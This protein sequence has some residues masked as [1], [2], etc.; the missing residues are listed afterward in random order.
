MLILLDHLATIINEA[1][2]TT[3]TGIQFME[4]LETPAPRPMMSTMTPLVGAGASPAAPAG[5]TD[6]SKPKGAIRTFQY[7]PGNCQHKYTR[8]MK[9][10]GEFC[11]NGPVTGTNFC[12]IHHKIKK[13]IASGGTTAV[14][15]PQPGSLIGA[16]PSKEAGT[17]RA[18]IKLR[19][20]IPT[21]ADQM[22]E[23]ISDTDIVVY[24][25][26]RVGQRL[27]FYVVGHGQPDGAVVDLNDE[28][29]AFVKQNNFKMWEDFK[30]SV[31]AAAA[32]K[33]SAPLSKP[34][35]LGGKPSGLSALAPKPSGLSAL[36]APKPSG[37][38][39]GAAAPAS[40]T[41]LGNAPKPSGLLG[42]ATAPAG[43]G[44]LGATP[45]PSGLLGAA[46]GNG[47][48]NSL[49]GGAP[50]TGLLGAAAKPSLLGGGTIAPA[51]VTPVA[52]EDIDD[53]SE[54]TE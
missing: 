13:N 27:V 19:D 9:E 39:L 48:G 23:K 51:A 20:W 32:A 52:P 8:E 5:A 47:A 24:R 42:A 37:G 28:E 11:A 38:L 36:A 10:K 40:N 50:K 3:Y 2:Q 30:D 14:S 25:P 7:V 45:K 35:G 6:K 29:R 46:A 21:D 15:T 16:A 22:L 49:L 33:P 12:H 43:N 17:T 44:L 1:H 54:F 53:P 41:L 26:D 34:G 4:A 18:S 31:V